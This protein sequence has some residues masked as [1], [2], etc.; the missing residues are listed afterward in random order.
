MLNRILEVKLGD[1][2]PNIT[3]Y[4]VSRLKKLKI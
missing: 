3:Q 1:W 4:E 2:K